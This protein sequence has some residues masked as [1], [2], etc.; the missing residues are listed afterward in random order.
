MPASSREKA[1][2]YWVTEHLVPIGSRSPEQGCQ[3][4][5]HTV[6]RVTAALRQLAPSRVALAEKTARRAE[7]HTVLELL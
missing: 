6:R 4:V 5:T 1:L 2:V 3:K 7:M